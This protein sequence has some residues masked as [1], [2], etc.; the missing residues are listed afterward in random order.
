MSK[1]KRDYI[2]L[3]RFVHIYTEFI[4]KVSELWLKVSELNEKV[5][6]KWVK[7]SELSKKGTISN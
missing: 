6:G 5:S 7:V 2:S 3:V 4:R 1:V